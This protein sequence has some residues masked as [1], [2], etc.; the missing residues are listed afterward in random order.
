[1]KIGKSNETYQL[2]TRKRKY[3]QLISIPKTTWNVRVF[4]QTMKTCV[5][6]KVAEQIE[7]Q[8][9]LDFSQDLYSIVSKNILI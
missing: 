7:E 2:K 1:M 4:G 3:Q 6:V 9:I 8:E 5:Y